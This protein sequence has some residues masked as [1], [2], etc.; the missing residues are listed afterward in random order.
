MPPGNI[1]D[2]QAV[3]RLRTVLREIIEAVVDGLPAPSAAVSDLNFFT[4]SA[5]VSTWLIRTDKGL[6][7]ERRWHQEYGGNPRLAFIAGQA[8]EF[9]DARGAALPS[10]GERVS[11][12][13]EIE[14]RHSRQE[15]R[16]ASGRRR[17]AAPAR[18]AGR[19]RW[20]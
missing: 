16:G 10:H 15:G 19:R 14:L 20:R 5:P 3:C 4:Q 8:A 7:A 1:P 13:G 11:A 9:P 2:I 17:S 6:S 18:R 12:R